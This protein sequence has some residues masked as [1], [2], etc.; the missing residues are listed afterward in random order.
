MNSVFKVTPLENKKL[1]GYKDKSLKE[2][3]EFFKI[4]W[5]YNTPKIFVVDDRETINLLRGKETEPWVVGWSSGKT[6]IFILNPDN[7][8]KESSHDGE[9]YNI[10]HLVKHELAHALFQIN[11][12]SSKFMWINEGVSIYLAGQLDKYPM[13]S[14]FEGFLDGN[15]VYQESGSAIMLLM[16]K[17]RKD[18]LFE[19]FKKQN[20]IEDAKGLQSLFKDIFGKELTYELFNTLRDESYN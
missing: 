5:V 16:D 12:G 11:F 3:N 18:K 7:I 4:R 2:L 20:G 6:G 19:F 8:S 1:Q 13:P 14:E 9:K 17:Y 10:E 15:K